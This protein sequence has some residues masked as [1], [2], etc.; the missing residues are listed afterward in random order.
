LI[1]AMRV[2]PDNGPGWRALLRGP[3]YASRSYFLNGRV[4]WN[5]PDPIYVR[6][7]VPI[8]HARLI[9]SW[10]TVAGGLSLCSEWLPALPADRMDLLKRTM[11][12][13]DLPARP[14]DLF[15]NDPPRIWLLT[16]DRTEPPR[17]LIGIYNWTSEPLKIDE[18]LE[19]I[20][21]PGDGPYVAFDFWSNR[22]IPPFKGR[23][24]TTLPKESC[25][26]LSVR[27]VCGHPQLI[28]T[29][30]HITQ[31]MVDVVWEKWEGNSLS[32]ASRVVGGDVYELRIMTP[33]KNC[34]V[35]SVSVSSTDAAAGVKIT[36]E[37]AA[38]GVRVKI[39]SNDNREVSWT[40]RFRHF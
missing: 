13:H 16:D 37:R 23:L 18:S 15:D 2:G 24:R 39:E 34:K 40:V 11:P 14:V 31:G 9:C 38:D 12:S 26:V 6:Q 20:G 33:E 35:A 4:W 27:R 10:V 29:S 17:D 7:S 25:Q 22:F 1:D 28:S 3:T 36:D 5:D 32:G 21:L 19:R 30:R 8:E